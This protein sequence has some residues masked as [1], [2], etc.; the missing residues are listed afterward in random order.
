MRVN[1][2]ANISYL[3]AY[4]IGVLSELNPFKRHQIAV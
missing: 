1:L 2:I 3:T 4:L